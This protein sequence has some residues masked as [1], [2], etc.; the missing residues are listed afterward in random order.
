M[1]VT[2]QQ[3]Y[4]WILTNW[5]NKI[6]FTKTNSLPASGLFN[7]IYLLTTNNTFHYWDGTNM[8]DFG[9]NLSDIPDRAQSVQSIEER[10]AIT[11]T[12]RALGKI[13]SYRDSNLTPITKRFDGNVVEDAVW[14]DESNWTLLGG[15]S[16]D[17]NAIDEE[18][19][20]KILASFTHIS[21]EESADGMFNGV[22][23]LS[24]SILSY[25]DVVNSTEDMVIEF[26]VRQSA[27]QSTEE[28]QAM[29]F[30][31]HTA[32][33]AI[34]MSNDGLLSIITIAGEEITLSTDLQDDKFHTIKVTTPLYTGESNK[35]TLDIDDGTEVFT[36]D[37]SGLQSP[38]D[39]WSDALPVDWYAS[40]GS[41]SVEDV[42][43]DRFK[44]AIDKV[45]VSIGSTVLIDVPDVRSGD[46][47]G[48]SS[49][50]FFTENVYSIS[51]SKYPHKGSSIILE[52]NKTLEE[53]IKDGDF[54]I[55]QEQIEALNKVVDHIADTPIPEP[56]GVLAASG[57][58]LVIENII[59]RSAVGS[60][61][62]LIKFDVYVTQAIIDNDQ[63]MTVF[64]EGGNDGNDYDVFTRAAMF[65]VNGKLG[66]YYDLKVDGDFVSSYIYDIAESTVGWHTIEF[67]LSDDLNSTDST[68]SIDSSALQVF[69]ASNVPVISYV[70]Y[71][72][73]LYINKL[74]FNSSDIEVKI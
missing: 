15:N 54:G 3:L 1:A 9:F 26:I 2:T 44:G 45:K 59:T 37:V 4:D 57:S 20:A 21:E 33:G 12:N 30:L 13:V 49:D 61:T 74:E 64:A 5:S 17:S 8:L 53:A 40:I 18:T 63:W 24:T 60:N 39:T 42:H 35:Y 47:E 72:S 7:T 73:N 10:D 67:T 68:C 50:E 36:L 6:S 56:S 38:G 65:S 34:T 14:T 16:E 52:S 19:L 58:N 51:P 32:L 11:I 43:E 70:D 22:D 62:R 29:L 71:D 31:S 48:V 28:A 25:T 41:K 23:S 55:S 69:P 27:F 46:N 66:A